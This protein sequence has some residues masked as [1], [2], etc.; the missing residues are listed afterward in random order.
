L[1]AQVF[2]PTADHLSI[3]VSLWTTH[4]GALRILAEPVNNI[5]LRRSRQLFAAKNVGNYGGRAID[6]PMDES[7][8]MAG[9][10]ARCPSASAGFEIRAHHALPHL[11]RRVSSSKVE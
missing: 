10:R 6:L 4:D 1:P 2:Q 5:N 9:F 8:A 11:F 7:F 3:Q